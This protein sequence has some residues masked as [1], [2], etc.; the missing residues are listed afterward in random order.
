MFPRLIL[1]WLLPT[2]VTAFVF[3]PHPGSCQDPVPTKPSDTNQRLDMAYARTMLRLS[4]ARLRQAQELNRRVANTVSKANM[5][6]LRANVEV[7]RQAVASVSEGEASGRASVY[8]RLGEMAVA[9]A[10][11]R[12]RKAQ[13]A[14]ERAPSAYSDTDMEI[15]Q[16]ELDM[17]RLNLATGQ[18]ALKGST[19]DKLNWKIEVLYAEVIRLRNELRQYKR[20][21]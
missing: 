11:S 10:E 1:P 17:A 13:A 12:L 15:L 2:V 21:G 20:R 14:R 3:Q 6:D 5:N 7:A 18:Q 4:E 16:L 8:L 19:E 9:S